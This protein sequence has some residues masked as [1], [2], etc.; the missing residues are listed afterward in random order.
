[1]NF[2]CVS[3]PFVPRQRGIF[4]SLSATLWL[5]LI[6]MVLNT[7]F[8]RAQ[9]PS[10]SQADIETFAQII[11]KTSASPFDIQDLTDKKFTIYWLH[12]DR[13]TSRDFYN[14]I[15]SYCGFH[16]AELEYRWSWPDS[17]IAGSNNFNIVVYDQEMTWPSRWKQFSNVFRI[18]IGTSS[19]PSGYT[20]LTLPDIHRGL[21]DLSAQY[22][23][24]GVKV[25]NN[26]KLSSGERVSYL[27]AFYLGLDEQYLTSQ[28]DSIL[29][30]GLDSMAYPGA[31]VSIAYK[32]SVVYQKTVGYHTYNQDYLVRPHDLYDLASLTKVT[33]GVNALMTLYDNGK[34][35]LDK[36]LADYFPYY[37]NSD[38]ASLRMK[39]ILTHSAGLIPYMVYYNM[40][41]KEKDRYYRNTLSPTRHG[42]YQYRV[43]DSIFVSDRFNRFVYEAIKDSPVKPGNKYKYSGLFFLLIP[44]LVNKLSGMPLDK[45]LYR[46]I[47]KPLGAYSTVFNP[48]PGININQIVPTEVDNSW[49]NQLVHGQVH[50]EAAAV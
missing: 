46:N 10:I 9:T 5:I 41:Q 33:A 31:E 1:M 47:Y 42:S 35:D 21:M 8:L 16:N 40:V 14:R 38:K 13:R 7:S 4:Y 11:Q 20:G 50:D 29:Q 30:L 23:M 48:A 25:E 45:Y 3:T 26:G 17:L 36:T 28:L 49:R 12:T 22:I 32:G 19:P 2:K 44:D 39:R 18:R 37:R 24:K 27:P 6:L 15:R 34:F 43:T